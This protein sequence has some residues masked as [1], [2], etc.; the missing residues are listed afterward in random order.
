MTNYEM[1]GRIIEKIDEKMLLSMLVIDEAH[2]IKNPRAMRTRYIRR[3]DNE[4]ERILLMTGTPLENHVMEMCSL[5]DFIRPDL[6]FQV[7]EAAA[8]ARIPEFKELIAPVYLRRQRSQVLDE[9]PPVTWK[10]EWCSLT[11]QD[12]DAYLDA[13]SGRSFPSMRRVSFLQDD[14]AGS[15]KA[16]RLLEICATAEQEGRKVLIYSY[17]RETIEKAAQLLGSR[18]AGIITGSVPAA[19]RQAVVD[20][21]PDAPAGCALVCQVQAAGTGLNIQ[22][23]SV[24]IFCEPQIK[25]SLTSQAVSRAQRMGQVRNVIVFHLLCEGTV[26]EAVMQILQEKQ[27]EFD[28]Y[29]DESAMAGA[30]ADIIDSRWISSFIEQENKKYLPAVISSGR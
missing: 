12:R 19:D 25:P 21:F 9:L 13:L 15:S 28:T 16:A 26:D 2:Y 11:D 24:I 17:F 22:A 4:S 18:C 20:R 7:R 27:E 1:M 6:S 29:A 8:I 23:A 10:E 30:M 5:I 3:L 14:L